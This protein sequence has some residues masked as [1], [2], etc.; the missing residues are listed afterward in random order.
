[1]TVH[2]RWLLAFV[3]FAVVLL[4]IFAAAFLGEIPTRLVQI[5][6]YDTIGHLVLYGILAGLL[7]LALGH[8]QTRIVRT[9]IGIPTAALVVILVAITDELAQGLSPVRT[10]D[11]K[12]VAADVCGIAILLLV[13]RRFGKKRQGF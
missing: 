1:M 13:T 10:R 9:P 11:V 7:D 5:P 8:H 4:G 6:Y 12:D 3:L 2:R